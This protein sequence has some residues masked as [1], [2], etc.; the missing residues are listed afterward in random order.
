M[1]RNCS[2]RTSRSVLPSIT[3]PRWRTSGTALP[4]GVSLGWAAIGRRRPNAG[5]II[6]GGLAQDVAGIGAYAMWDNHLYFAGTI[7]R[8]AHIGAAQPNTGIGCNRINIRGVAP[9]WRLAW[10]Q[11]S[12]N[13]NLMVGTYGMHMKSTPGGITGL[14]DGYTDWAADFQDDR[15]I[16][17]SG[18]MLFP[19]GAHT[20]AKIRRFSQRS[21]AAGRSSSS[22]TS[23]QFRRMLST[24]SATSTPP[25]S[26]ISYR[27]RN[28]RSI[29][30]PGG[31]GQRKC[32]WRPA[33]QRIHR[34]IS[35]GGPFRTSA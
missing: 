31:P 7:Y 6:N 23:I 1:P 18:E 13:N 4:R 25:P 10:Q 5:A 3:I 22:I 11:N 8:S 32:E 35:R 21:R 19:S 29:A 12:K 20:S 14:E 15:T 30:F 33:K 2:R 34:A 9:Y 16:P 27:Y 24:I 28:T 26:D 17:N